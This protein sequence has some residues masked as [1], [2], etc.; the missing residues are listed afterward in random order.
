MDVGGVAPQRMWHQGTRA[1]ALPQR[2]GLHGEAC[3]RRAV[4]LTAR[5]PNGRDSPHPPLKPSPHRQVMVTRPVL[6]VSMGGILREAETATPPGRGQTRS[7]RR[8]ASHT[9]GTAPLSRLT[10]RGIGSGAACSGSAETPSAGTTPGSVRSIPE[11][12]SAINWKGKCLSWHGGPSGRV[13]CGCYER[14]TEASRF[15][16]PFVL[17]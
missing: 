9:A 10:A 13:W 16:P 14:G 6:S 11:Q 12:R 4:R 2:Y 15:F 7:C 1:S 5:W 8:A 3:G 17:A